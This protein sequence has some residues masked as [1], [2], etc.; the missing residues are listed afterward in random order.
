MKSEMVS[1]FDE[2]SLEFAGGQLAVSPHDGLSLFGAYESTSSCP[3]MQ[4][5]YISIGTPEGL[6][7]WHA[8]SDVLNGQ[9]IACQHDLRLWPPFP[10][11]DVA[12]GYPWPSK[13]IRT[14]PLD[15]EALLTASRKGDVHER[16]YAVIG[17]ILNHLETVQKLDI[18]PSVAV[19]IIP[20]EI[21]RNCRPLSVVS[22]PTTPRISSQ[23]KKLRQTGQLDLFNQVNIEQYLL[24]PDFRRQLK[25]RTM[26][27]DLPVQIVRES[28]LRLSDENKF[29]QRGL[30]PVSDRMWNLST[31]LYYKSGGKPWK[32]STARKGVC[33][34]GLAFRRLSSTKSKRTACC[35]A[36]MFVDS[37]DG[38]EPRN[39]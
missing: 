21:F 26:K 9:H 2:P 15:R 34:V 36:Q 18:K 31:A 39:K 10:G 37:G 16:C 14:F 33:Y 29:G 24:A 12:F 30:T 13:E 4:T 6:D 3:Q 1:I 5:R 35:A 17:L 38:V 23:T 32:L 11:F 8:W 28:T 25:A 27:F 7:Q 22:A 20:D 19:C